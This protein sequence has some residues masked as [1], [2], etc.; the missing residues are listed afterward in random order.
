MT[1]VVLSNS[2]QVANIVSSSL[3]E[4]FSACITLTEAINASVALPGRY[5]S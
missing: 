1:H 5:E 3:S 4:D 2:S